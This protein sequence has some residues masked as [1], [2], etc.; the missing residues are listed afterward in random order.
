[1]KVPFSWIKEFVDVDVSAQELG[2]KL[3][4]YKNV[5]S[6]ATEALSSSCSS[7][8]VNTNGQKKF[9]GAIQFCGNQNDC[10]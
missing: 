6:V 9:S 7:V 1:M 10:R 5:K 2:D 3:V 8:E 4:Y